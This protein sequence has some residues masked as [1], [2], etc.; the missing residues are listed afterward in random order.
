MKRMHDE[1]GGV[2]DEGYPRCSLGKRE[3][4]KEVGGTSYE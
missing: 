3:K 4:R 2:L 1:K